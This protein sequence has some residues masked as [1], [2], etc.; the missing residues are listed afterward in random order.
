MDDWVHDPQ[1]D[2]PVL[3][4]IIRT[5]LDEATKLEEQSLMDRGLPE[6]TMAAAP[7][8]WERAAE[9]LRYRYGIEW[10]DPMEMTPGLF[11]D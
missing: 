9:I 5:V 7:W 3:G 11:V 1:E 2:D 8:V 10:K 4:P 6:G